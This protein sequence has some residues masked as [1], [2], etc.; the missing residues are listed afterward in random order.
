MINNMNVFEYVLNIFMGVLLIGMLV[1]GI[2]GYFKLIS[3]V[4][5][6]LFDEEDD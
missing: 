6:K 5:D 3:R 1:Y 4:G 2:Y